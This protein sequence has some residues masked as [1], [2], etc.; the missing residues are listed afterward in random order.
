MRSAQG[1]IKE[2]NWIFHECLEYKSSTLCVH[3]DSVCI[4]HRNAETKLKSY[5]VFLLTLLETIIFSLSK[6]KL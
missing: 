1:S 3:C 6:V 4:I 5:A 2:S